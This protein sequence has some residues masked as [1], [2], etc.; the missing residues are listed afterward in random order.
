VLLIAFGGPGKPEDIRPFLDI[1]TAGRR[2]SPSRIAEVAHHYE[3]IGGRSPLTEL[4][5]R[6]AE[7]LGEALHRLG[8]AEA[9]YVGMR[10]WHPFLQETLESMR[11]RGHRRA[12][13]VILSSLQTEASWERY[14]ADVVAA[15]A[16]DALAEVPPARRDSTLLVFTA[17][18]VPVAMAAGSPYSRQ[19]EATA[20]MV[21]AHLGHSRWQVAYQSRSG[22]PSDPWLEPDICDVLRGLAGTETTSVVVLPIGFVCDHVEVLY[23]LDVEARAVAEGIGV[24]FHRAQTANDHPAFIAMLADLVER[25]PR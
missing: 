24:S 18:S 5:M 21:A 2:I 17:H 6:Q 14:V 9:V 11:A 10:N 12:L 23:D 16:A 3:I 19:F 13:G 20:H 25:G 1:V 4:T 15:R 22:A 7:A 8:R